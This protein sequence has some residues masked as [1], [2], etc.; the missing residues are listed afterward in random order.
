MAILRSAFVQVH[1][2]R[3]KQGMPEYLLLQRAED[4]DMYPGLWQMI[5]GGIEEGEHALDTAMRELRE[6]CGL[7]DCTLTVVPYVAAF[8]LVEDDSINLHPVFAAEAPPEQQI[9]LSDEHQ[10]QGWFEYEAAMELLVFP[11]HKE[12]LRLLHQSLVAGSNEG[13]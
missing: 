12:G 1:V 13:P 9:T 4:N 11:G 8:Y 2:Y 7:S 6:E 5:T 3:W 10:Q